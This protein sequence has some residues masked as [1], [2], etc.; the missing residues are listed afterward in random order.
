MAKKKLAWFLICAVL[1]SGYGCKTTAFAEGEQIVGT[2]ETQEGQETQEIM[3]LDE[4]NAE[5]SD[6]EELNVGIQYQAHSA[7][8]GWQTAV[9]NGAIAGTTGRSLAMQAIKINLTN[10]PEQYQADSGVKYAMHVQT[11]GWQTAVANGDVA[12]TVGQSKR[13]EA[14]TIELTGSI[15][16]K[17]DVYYRVHSQTYGWMGWAK[18]GEKAGTIGY[19]KRIEAI[20]IQLV[21]KGGAA[22]EGTGS[23]YAYPRLQYQTHVQN[24]GWM[25][26]VCEGAAAGTTGMSKRLEAIKIQLPDA[27]YEGGIQYRVYTQTYG[28]QDWKANG[29][30]AGTVGESKRI[31]AVEIALTGELANHYDV[32]YSLHLSKI[33]WTD[34]AVNGETAGS[35]DLA[36]RVEAIK[37]ELVKKGESTNLATSGVKYIKG[38]PESALYYSGTVEGIGAT[39]NVLQGGTLGTVGESK[40]LQTIILSLDRTDAAMPNGMIQ[41]ATHVASVGWT[42]WVEQGTASGSA[43]GTKNIEAVKITLSGDIANYYDVY[44]RAQVQKYGWLGWAKNG[45]AAGT[46][47]CGYRMEALQVKLVPKDASKPGANANYYT[48]SK[49]YSGPDAGMAVRADMYSS[50]TP[51]IIMVDRSTCRLGIYQGW[52]GNWNC[53][54]YWACAVGAS[55]T[56]TVSGEFTV[57]SRGYYFNSGAYRCYWWT[58]FYGD[59]LFHS[60]LYN[61]GTRLMDGRLGMAISHGC[62]RL[63]INNAK[64]IYDTIPAGTK[65]VVYN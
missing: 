47:T 13:G 12:G 16:A 60:V 8:I 52:Q 39:G 15:A 48:E 27:E 20:E 33:G 38:Y 1:I 30:I 7:K 40:G 64:W 32:Y 11:Y 61:H 54:Q 58:Q 43:D 36:K 4:S 10:L 42:N 56:P 21:K 29:A 3:V 9:E 51:Y 53:V 50:V 34:Y 45:Q 24:Y 62:I 57:G 44:Y 22:P 31:E 19:A 55:S 41:Y 2:E 25:S 14:I 23:A 28:W 49:K 63:D 6:T 18:N 46:T 37:I 17:Y 35:T 59:Y 65:V 5:G 26:T